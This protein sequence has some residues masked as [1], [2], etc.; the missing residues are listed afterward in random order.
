MPTSLQV[1]GALWNDALVLQIAHAFQLATDY[2]L[3][4]PT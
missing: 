1:S 4:R 3:T 2:H